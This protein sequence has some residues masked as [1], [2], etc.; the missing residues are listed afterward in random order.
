MLQSES[1]DEDLEH[2][3][4]VLEDAKEVTHDVSSDPIKSICSN[5]FLKEM[6]ETKVV[7]SCH[8]S[9]EKN[10]LASRISCGD[11]EK[12]SLKFC[13]KTTSVIRYNPR[14]REPAYWYFS[15]TLCFIISLSS[16]QYSL[17]IIIIL[18]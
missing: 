14:H 7:D 15:F 3:T 2:F 10:D 8:F 16:F 11:S 13:E 1:A 4:D 6:D 5:A 12:E 9:S 17:S 18:S